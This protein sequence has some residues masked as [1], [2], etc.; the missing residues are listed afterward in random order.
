MDVP[1]SK[2]IILQPEKLSKI[3]WRAAVSSATPSPTA[4]FALTLATASKRWIRIN[5]EADDE[6]TLTWG[7]FLILRTAGSKE[8]PAFI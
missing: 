6:L 4:P 5:I 3:A 1:A 7:V 8:F 2:K